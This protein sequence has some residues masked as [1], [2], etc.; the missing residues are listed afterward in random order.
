V[1]EQPG[2]ADAIGRFDAQL[3][4][5]VVRARH[6]AATA[7]ETGAAFRRETRQLAERV[8][9]GTAAADQTTDDGLRRAAAGFRADHGLPVEQLPPVDPA[10]ARGPLRTPGRGR[11]KAHPGD[12]DEDFSQERIMQ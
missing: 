10:A 11:P 9:T 4:A 12:D 1:T 3:D 5:A 7:R 8:K 6:A 2:F